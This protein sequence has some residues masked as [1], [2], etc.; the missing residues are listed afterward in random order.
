MRLAD[1]IDTPTAIRHFRLG[2]GSLNLLLLGLGGVY[3][4]AW[5]HQYT[6]LQNY[7]AGCCWSRGRA[8]KQES[9]APATQV[10]EF[11]QL[12][13]LVYQPQLRMQITEARIPTNAGDTLTRNAISSLTINLP[14]ADPDT[15]QAELTLV[16]NSTPTSARIFGSGTQGIPTDQGGAWLAGSRCTWIPAGEGQGLRLSGPFSRSLTRLS[17][18]LRYHSPVALLAGMESVIGGPRGLAYALG[19][20]GLLSEGQVIA[21][22]AGDPTPELDRA[23]PH[24]LDP[25]YL[26][27][28]DS[29]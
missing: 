6:P 11:E 20:D 15:V 1:K 13:M 9:I 19:P 16:G 4:Y 24:R 26:Q 18:R 5:S 27:P 25:D 2:M 23:T 3:L 12:L 29:A 8:Y 17:L 14:G 7:L 21:L 10:A 28:K 22:R